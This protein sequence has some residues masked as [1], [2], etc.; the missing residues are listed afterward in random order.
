MDQTPRYLLKAGTLVHVRKV[1][2]NDRERRQYRLRKQLKFERYERKTETELTFREGGWI[3][4]V[5]RK[6]VVYRNRK[7][8]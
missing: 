3:V 5:D 1:S 6:R 4:A 7:L 8:A 2:E